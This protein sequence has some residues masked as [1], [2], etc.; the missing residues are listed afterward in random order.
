MLGNTSITLLIAYPAPMNNTGKDKVLQAAVYVLVIPS[1]RARPAISST[2]LQHNDSNN[3]EGKESPNKRR[4]IKETTPP[5][6][7]LLYWPDSP[8]A[9]Q[10]FRQ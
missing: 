6:S 3:S 5:Q 10:V 4:R 9:R 8:E 2:S 1:T 7:L